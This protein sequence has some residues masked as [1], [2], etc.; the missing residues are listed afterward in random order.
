MLGGAFLLLGGFLRWF[1]CLYQACCLE[2]AFDLFIWRTLRDFNPLLEGL[3][4]LDV[5][6]APFD[7]RAAHHHV[8]VVE[9]VH[10]DA[11]PARLMPRELH[12]NST[13]FH[14]HLNTFT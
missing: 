7:P 3:E 8:Y 10:Y 14:H 4:V 13:Y 9:Y 12:T 2:H 11:P 6:S 5:A 1:L